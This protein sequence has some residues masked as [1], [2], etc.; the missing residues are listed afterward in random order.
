[1]P[2]LAKTLFRLAPRQLQDEVQIAILELKK[3]GIGLGVAA[4]LFVGALVLVTFLVTS[5]LVA[6]IAGIAG[7]G[8]IAITALIVAGAF[9][10]IAAI[11]AL[12]GLSRLKKNLPL[13]PNRAI[14][15][16]K[17]DIG[18]LKEGRRF[19]ERSLV[20][21]R[22]KEQ[23][24]ADA[25]RA[26]EER[27]A[28][29]RQQ[30]I[31]QGIDPD[32]KPLTLEQLLSLTSQ[33]R[34][35]IAGTRDELVEELPIEDP[36]APKQAG[37]A[38]RSP[39]TDAAQAVR[40][41]QKSASRKLGEAKLNAETRLEQAKAVA[42]EKIEARSNHTSTAAV[43]VHGAHAPSRPARVA[44]QGESLADRLA[45]RK[46]AVAAAGASL[47]VFAVLA[48]KLGRRK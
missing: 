11:L 5:L 13:K 18:V 23:R 21:T 15:G 41:F 2:A 12:V 48:S 22:T 6:M 24:E 8:R 43:G 33:R 38:R 27:E 35:N 3:K 16:I 4:G 19:D 34:Q 26:A 39:K 1:M 32:A 42:A 37:A 9:L 20:D 7:A 30:K 14:R 25:K 36:A 29:K 47:S 17:H 44:G 28:K 45:E 46:G 40:S 31:D 10:V